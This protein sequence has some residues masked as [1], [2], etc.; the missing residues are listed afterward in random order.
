M[1]EDIKDAH[2]KKIKIKQEKKGHVM[3]IKHTT[4]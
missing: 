2:R 3:V 1:Y 4:T